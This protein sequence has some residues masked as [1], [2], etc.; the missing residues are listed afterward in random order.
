MRVNF[1]ALLFAL[2]VCPC[3]A[4]CQETEGGRLPSPTPA[5]A[6]SREERDAFVESVEEGDADAVR[7]FL[8]AGMSL[9]VGG[10][11]GDELLSVAMRGKHF[12]VVEVLLGH[13]ARLEE[14][15]RPDLEVAL[16]QAVRLVQ[17]RTVRLLLDHGAKVKAS[18]GKGHTALMLIAGGASVA[19]WPPESVQAI[20]VGDDGDADEEAALYKHAPKADRFE[21]LRL[22]LDR[23]AD[24]NAV[25]DDCG[26]TALI[27]AAMFGSPEVT[28]L[29][30]EKGA[31][32]NVGRKDW[33]ALYFA[34]A[35]LE[36]LWGEDPDGE[37]ETSAEE[38]SEFNGLFY[39]ATNGRAEVARLLREAGAREPWQW[40]EEKDEED[41]GT[42]NP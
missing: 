25:A 39:A 3:F 4:L 17:P 13:A 14:K 32:P 18:D 27:M 15:Q 2:F 19:D 33:N 35:G 31:D 12:E 23:G 30:L 37:G 42:L 6:F 41:A 8:S 28:R 9:S 16:I 11:K 29:L 1:P 22:L 36:E 26:M 38:R 20:L 7:R 34:T 21:V 24:V 40:P 10:D 5:D